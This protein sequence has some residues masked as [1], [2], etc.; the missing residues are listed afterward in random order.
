MI[1]IIQFVTL[2][3]ATPGLDPPAIA[4]VGDHY[5]YEPGSTG[6]ASNNEYYTSDMLWERYGCHHAKNNYCTKPDMS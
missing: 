3:D 1:I 6:S 4:I 2:C 5:Y